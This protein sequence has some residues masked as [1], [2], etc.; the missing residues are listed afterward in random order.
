MSRGAVLEKA[1]S[2]ARS[3]AQAVIRT[4]GLTQEY[5][6]GSEIASELFV[7]E[8]TVKTHVG[9]ILAKLGARDRVQAVVAA[10]D[11]GLVQPHRG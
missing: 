7:G 1:D 9:R 11:S 8:A 2:P 10:Y 4:E 6:L 5:R 3:I